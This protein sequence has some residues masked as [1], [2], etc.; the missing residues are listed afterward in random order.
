MYKFLDFLLMCWIGNVLWT[1]KI[2]TI[3]TCA[4]EALA[5]L[6]CQLSVFQYSHIF[7]IHR[8]V[9]SLILLPLPSLASVALVFTFNST[10][11]PSILFSDL[12]VQMDA[13]F[14]SHTWLPKQ[15]LSIWFFTRHKLLISP[16]LLFVVC[17][18]SPLLV[19][20]VWLRAG[21]M[22]TLEHHLPKH[23]P[24]FNGEQA[25]RKRKTALIPIQ[26]QPSS[27]YCPSKDGFV[28]NMG[29]KEARST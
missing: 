22:E 25:E 24:G 20:M 13:E 6:C 19:W 10:S 15:A 5:A 17:T 14:F 11:F 29:N 2:R 23:H 21:E 4:N 8:L 3:S 18:V 1:I 26:R 12:N 9:Q 7:I 27:S 16:G 28:I